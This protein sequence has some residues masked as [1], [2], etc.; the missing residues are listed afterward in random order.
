L[1]GRAPILHDEHQDAYKKNIKMRTTITLDD[2]LARE[3][4]ERARKTR[5]SFKE[6]VNDAVRVGL[7]A[8]ESPPM[9]ARHMIKPISMGQPHPGV[10]LK[11][12]LHL[13]GDLEDV[14]VLQKLE[15]RK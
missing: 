6:V 2:E 10:D 4:Q 5:R 14:A 11:K 1:T 15:L 9:P 13:A 12:A 8:I 7:R 3:L